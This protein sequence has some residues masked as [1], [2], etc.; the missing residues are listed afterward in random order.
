MVGSSIATHGK[1]VG[2]SGQAMVFPMSTGSRPATRRSPC[3]HLLGPLLAQALKL[4]QL[5]DLLLGVVT[6][7]VRSRSPAGPG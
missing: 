5:D 2:S 4:I 6:L 7:P 1:A 3:L